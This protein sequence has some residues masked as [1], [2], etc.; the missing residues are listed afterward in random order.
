MAE[1]SALILELNLE[2]EGLDRGLKEIKSK[3]LSV[4]GSIDGSGSRVG[5]TFEGVTNQLQSLGKELSNAG[6]GVSTLENSA[7]TGL[8]SSF[9]QASESL[10]KLQQ[11]IAILQ[12]LSVEIDIEIPISNVTQAQESTN[13]LRDSFKGIE[14][15][16]GNSGIAGI[17]NQITEAFKRINE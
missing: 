11:T 17:I 13:S 5:S 16:I 15:E 4:L 2:T 8:A 12:S 7:G 3:F 14:N 1:I 10:D 6:K 9:N